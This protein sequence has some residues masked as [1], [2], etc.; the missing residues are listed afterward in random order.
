MGS[1]PGGFVFGTARGGRQ[2]SV[3]SV[4]QRILAPAIDLA[5]ERL[6]AAGEAPLP[7]GITP[8][9]LR[10]AFVSL[11]YALGQDPPSVMAEM[12]HTD[13]GL[14]LRIYAQSMPRDD[15]ER[16]RIQALVNGD[17]AVIGTPGRALDGSDAVQ[18]TR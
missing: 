12:G 9:S 8:H 17:L 6:A 18:E 2:R 11:L 10:R 7:N 5:N 16:A 13:P 3:S 15:A 1:R 14:A 4:K